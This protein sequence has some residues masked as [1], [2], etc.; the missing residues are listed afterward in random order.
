MPSL[1]LFICTVCQK[2]FYKDSLS[3][4]RCHS[5]PANST[6]NYIGSEHIRDCS[7]HIPYYRESLNDPCQCKYSK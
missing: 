1:H 3:P 4:G 6:T 7:C 5:C 2:G